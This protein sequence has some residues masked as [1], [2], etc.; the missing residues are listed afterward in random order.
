MLGGFEKNYMHFGGK[1]TGDIVF[2]SEP[3]LHIRTDSLYI[4]DFSYIDTLLGNAHLS[5]EVLI[6][7][8]FVTIAADIVTDSIYHSHAEFDLQ[9]AKHDSMD[10]RVDPD[11]LPLGF[12][13]NW[14]GSIL[15]QF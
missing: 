11:H 13:N 4:Q 15:Q 5:A 7:S 6:P 8:K 1:A 10:L 12:I 14:T 9:L 2:N 3:D